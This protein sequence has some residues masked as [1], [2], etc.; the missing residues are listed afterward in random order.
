MILMLLLAATAFVWQ[1]MPAEGSPTVAHSPIYV[2]GNSAFTSANGV[3]AGN[4]SATSPFIIEG[5]N[6]TAAST[7]SLR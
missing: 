5:W 4:G 3:T 2:N 7:A 1:A 6:I